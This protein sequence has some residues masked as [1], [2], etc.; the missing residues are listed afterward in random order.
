MTCAEQYMKDHP[1]RTDYLGDC[2]STYGYLDDIEECGDGIGHE[3]CQKCW[4][5]EI[6]EE[7][8]KGESMP[9]EK[10]VMMPVYVDGKIV[11]DLTAMTDI[12]CNARRKLIDNGFNKEETFWVIKTLL[13][14]IV[15]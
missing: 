8:K 4:N 6:P 1:G 5:R 13:E 12:I 7:T 2:P 14:G 10:P 3:M 9:E 15:K 11:P